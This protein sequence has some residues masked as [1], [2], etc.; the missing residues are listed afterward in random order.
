MDKIRKYPKECV[1][2]F[3]KIDRF[4][5]NSSKKR[6]S[7]LERKRDVLYSDRL[8]GSI[9]IERYGKYNTEIEAELEEI[10][11]ELRKILS[12]DKNLK[13]KPSY[14]LNLA[15][16]LSKL[17]ESSQTEQKRQILKLLFANPEIKEKRLYFNLLEPFL[18]LSNCNKNQIWLRQLGS[19]QR[20][21]G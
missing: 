4:T 19:N 7:V 16:N 14:L 2:V 8:E 3:D 9:T 17:Y 13:I 12:D 15:N 11:N 1:V 10:N 20:P 18:T 21:I 6:H 5:R